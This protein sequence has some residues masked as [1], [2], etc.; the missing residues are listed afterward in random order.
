MD[1]EISSG[2]TI[3]TVDVREADA[4][5]DSTGEA[6][7]AGG[8]NI[9]DL[10]PLDNTVSG[11]KV[12]RTVTPTSGQR[13]VVATNQQELE[14]LIDG[15]AVPFYTSPYKPKLFAWQNYV[16]ATLP[17]A[18]DG[19]H[20]SLYILQMP[21][22]EDAAGLY[23]ALLGFSEYS[24]KQ[25]TADDWQDPTSP[26]LGTDSRIQDTG[27][28]WWINFYKDGFYVEVMMDPS[29]GPAPDYAPGSPVLKAE[30][31]RF[32]QAVASRI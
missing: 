32:A 20:V 14:N 27:S 12:D 31:L 1:A 29:Y 30:A 23:K 8:K 2:G 28:Q 3:G 10:V 24:R 13:A 17:A 16:N 5:V 7:G 19:A 6:G 21:S 26:R 18:P 11:W 15:G 22:A 9:L 4:V 25:G